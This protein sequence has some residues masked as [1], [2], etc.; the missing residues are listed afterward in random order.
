MRLLSRRRTAG[1][2]LPINRFL[3]SLAEDQKSAAIGVILSGT[4]SDGTVGLQAIKSEGGVAF[5]QAPNRP[6]ILE[7]R[8]ARSWRGAWILSSRPKKLPGS[9]SGWSTCP[10]PEDRR[11]T[12]GG[13]AVCGRGRSS[14]DLY[15]LRTATGVDFSLYKTGTIKRRVARRMVLHKIDSLERYGSYLEQNEIEVA[16]LYQDIFIHVTNFFREPETFAALQRKVL[17]KLMADRPQSEPLRIW[18][19]GCSTGEEAYSIAITILEFLEQHKRA[20][21]AAVQIFG[22]DISAP[23]VDS[24]R[25]GTYSETAVANV[26]PERLKRFFVKVGDSYQIGKHVRE[27]CVFARH[28][29]GRIRLSPGS[30]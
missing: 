18:V 22:T 21:G 13:T 1:R 24:A 12:G 27:R 6:A 14:K 3:V 11:C 29:V 10:T 9:L 23:A 20:S 8:R 28:D 7:C 25:S 17:P 19:P 26:S 5:A 15:I 30:I 2:H 16:A 4:A